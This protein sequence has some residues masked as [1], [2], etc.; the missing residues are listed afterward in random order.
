MFFITSDGSLWGWGSNK[1]G[2]VGD[3][4][5]LP[6]DTPV[7]IMENVKSVSAGGSGFGSFTLAVK[8]D[9]SLWAWGKNSTSQLGD[10]SLAVSRSPIKLW[11]R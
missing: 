5:A 6:R 3:G 7:K 8:N 10:G 2:E 4:T 1:Y 11:S 9:G